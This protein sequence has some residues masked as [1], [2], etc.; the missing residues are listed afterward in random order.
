MCIRDRHALKTG[1]KNR[2]LAFDESLNRLYVGSQGEFGYFE[3]NWDYVSLTEKIPES[4]R[5]FDEVWDVF[6]LNSKVYFCT[7]QRIYVY[8][9]QSISAINHEDGFNKSFLIH[10]KV[11]TQSQKG[12]LIELKDNKLFTF[13]QEQKNQII[14]G[15][16]PQNEGYLLFYNSGKIE[17]S[18]SFG[19]SEKYD[20]LIQACLLYTSPSPRD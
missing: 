16:I 9:G 20:E 3:K 6:L 2:S 17:L 1:K 5:D 12:E 7:F 18:T 10:G 19:V 11:F 13:P 14:A 8:D 15:I 4:S